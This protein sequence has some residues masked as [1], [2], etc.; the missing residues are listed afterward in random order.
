ME[1]CWMTEPIK[2][3]SFKNIKDTLEKI[4]QN[5]LSVLI[6]FSLISTFDIFQKLK[7][8]LYTLKLRRLQQNAIMV[9]NMFRTLESLMM[10]TMIP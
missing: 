1:S 4:N 6:R 9:P 8:R 5:G 2:R 3:S 10:A 7:E